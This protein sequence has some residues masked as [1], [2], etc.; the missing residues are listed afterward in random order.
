MPQIT[1]KNV[2]NATIVVPYVGAI[3]GGATKTVTTTAAQRD[4]YGDLDALVAKGYI[5][6][7]HTGDDLR[8][9]GVL[10]KS[11][12]VVPSA[13]AGVAAPAGSLYLKT[14]GTVY[15]KTGAGATAWALNDVGGA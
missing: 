7:T 4:A 8:V 11:G 9:G 3:T 12:S 2:S 1:I 6:V 13:G 10:I 14:D 5:T 15:S